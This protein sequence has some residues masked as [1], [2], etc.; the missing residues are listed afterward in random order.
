MASGAQLADSS[1]GAIESRPMSLGDPVKRT[2]LSAVTL[3]KRALR[4]ALRLSMTGLSRGPHFTRVV[5]YERLG[6]VMAHERRTGDVL[7]ISR[8]RL[9]CDLLFDRSATITEAD[10]PEHNLLA[11]RF[12]TDAFDFVV[13]DQVI[14]HVEGS[15]QRAMDEI[16]RVLRPG[17]IAIVTTCLLYPIHEA[18]ADF[19][20][21]TPFGLRLLAKPFGEILDVG[22]W[23]NRFA[24]VLDWLEM[25]YE[26][27]PRAA[28]HPLAKLARHHE[29][30]WPI[31]T[32]LVARK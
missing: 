2:A 26:R 11:L 29:P 7:A 31:V 20:R 25:H 22:C 32:W 16:H 28:W 5:M 6:D 23:G 1:D 4:R 15:P 3:G 13:A 19:W 10:Y 30:E 14:E 8:S 24:W 18:P 9:V 17:G 27:L 21:F 12:P